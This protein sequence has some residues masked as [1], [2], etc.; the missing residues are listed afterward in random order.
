M[1]RVAHLLH[2]T[3]I[4][5]V[6]AAAD[7][8]QRAAIFDYRVFAF[9][10]HVPRAV[11]ADVIGYGIN[12]PR[13]VLTL[14]RR[15]RHWGPDL[16]VSSLWRSVVIGGVHRLF[17]PR[18]PWAVYVHNTRYL[19]VF[20][21]LA[22]RLAYPFADQILCDSNAARD[23]LVP[24]RLWGRTVV[25]APSSKLLE[26]ARSQVEARQPNPHR[27]VYFGRIVDFK[28]F[29]R[30]LRLLSA[31]E[32]IAPGE[33]SLDLV[34]PPSDLLDL[35]LE[36]AQG[37][38]LRVTWWG[39]GTAEEIVE[40]TAGSAFYLLL[41]ENEGQSMAVHE[42]LALGL[43]PIV[44]PVGAIAEYTEDGTNAVHV[45]TDKHIDPTGVRELEDADYAEAARR[46]V[47]LSADRSRL[48]RMSQAAREVPC[49]DFIADFDAAVTGLASHSAVGPVR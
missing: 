28:R 49:G 1:I 11:R 22:H 36:T 34:S 33:Y 6:E 12:S 35:S 25:V 29:D 31:L 48:T 15:L 3:G 8:L 26:L 32:D 4:G 37:Q 14:L 7:S 20:D 40:R 13:S 42:A 21:K 24:Q 10:D 5:G 27:L 18:T 47:S 19:H 16:V 39:P 41:S 2:T 23:Q 9:E 46:I 38:G 17:H 44:T 45:A 43:V 30:S